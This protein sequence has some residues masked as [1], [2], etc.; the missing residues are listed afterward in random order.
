VCV[1]VFFTFS[2]VIYVDVMYSDGYC[3]VGYCY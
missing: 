1:N 2:G 3:A